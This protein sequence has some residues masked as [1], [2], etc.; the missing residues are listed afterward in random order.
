MA[1]TETQAPEIRGSQPC[2]DI[3]ETI[4]SAVTAALLEPNGAGVKIKVVVHNQNFAG[5]NL[6]A[7]SYT[8]L[9]TT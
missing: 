2:L 7:V 3:L 5:F 6:V 4:M 8:H 9:G 1:D